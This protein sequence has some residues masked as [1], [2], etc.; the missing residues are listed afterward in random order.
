MRY[1]ALILASAAILPACHGGSADQ[2]SY[3]R[4]LA[5]PSAGIATPEA[6]PRTFAAVDYGKPGQPI[7]TS[8]EVSQI[9]GVL[10]EIK[11][12][13]RPLLRYTLLPDAPERRRTAVFFRIV[14]VGTGYLASHV[15]GTNN[16]IYQRNG[17][18]HATMYLWSD[19]QAIDEEKCVGN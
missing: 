10:S 15:F 6:T 16:L 3:M 1:A 2:S 19:K 7:L 5:L 12:C 11:P 4:G 13:Q 8:K 9:Q 14:D 18:V 17:E